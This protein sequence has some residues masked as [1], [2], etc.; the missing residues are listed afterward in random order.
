[1]KSKW[2][3]CSPNKNLTINTLLKYLPENLIEYVIFHEMVHL[4]ERKHNK[5]FWKFIAIKFDN[6]EEKEK[7]LFEYWFLIQKKI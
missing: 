6:Y 2:G 5:L 4:I 1:I 3:S 7:E